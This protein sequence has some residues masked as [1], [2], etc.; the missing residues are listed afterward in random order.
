VELPIEAFV[1]GPG[2]IVV[3]EWI[4]DLQERDE[5]LGIDV[6]DELQHPLLLGG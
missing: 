6:T 4:Q 2:S 3:R 5:A 1:L